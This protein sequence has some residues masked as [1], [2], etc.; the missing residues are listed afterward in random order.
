[1]I[2]V[3]HRAEKPLVLTRHFLFA[4]RSW[5][6]GGRIRHCL[7]TVKQWISKQ[8]HDYA[9]PRFLSAGKVLNE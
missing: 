2:I 4:V 7:E 9:S 6:R 5:S 3:Q 8:K 1:M